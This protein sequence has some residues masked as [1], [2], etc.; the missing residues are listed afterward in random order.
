M[1]TSKEI[2]K[3]LQNNLGKRATAGL[4]STDT[5]ALVTATNLSK[6]IS[7][8]SAPSQL[9]DAYRE[10]VLQMLPHNRQLAYHAIACELDWSHREMIWQKSGLTAFAFDLIPKSKC[11]F[12]P[13]GGGVDRYCKLKREAKEL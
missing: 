8:E 1:K 7:Y 10:I 12:E 11:A 9:F 4:T 6:L 13:G 3:W 2:I 5:Y